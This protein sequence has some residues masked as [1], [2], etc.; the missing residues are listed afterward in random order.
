[1]SHVFL[2]DAPGPFQSTNMISTLVF[3]LRKSIPWEWCLLVCVAQAEGFALRLSDI[4]LAFT[5]LHRGVF[6]VLPCSE[7]CQ[8]P[9]QIFSSC[10]GRTHWPFTLWAGICAWYLLASQNTHLLVQVWQFSRYWPSLMTGTPQ[11]GCG[12]WGPA[13]WSCL[14][15]TPGDCKHRCLPV[16]QRTNHPTRAGQSSLPPFLLRVLPLLKGTPSPSA[17]LL[18]SQGFRHSG[19]RA[20]VSRRFPP[21][22][23]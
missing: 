16:A 14:R 3:F 22:A 8:G 23:L 18:G 6:L 20:A 2:S 4:P 17:V 10:C 12:I 1:M 19:Q 5:A 9:G 7:S 15:P 21:W 13:Q 11:G